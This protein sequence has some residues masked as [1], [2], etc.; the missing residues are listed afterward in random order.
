MDN[1][2]T[3]SHALY[4]PS[5]KMAKDQA[6]GHCT[7]N[8][9]FQTLKFI[10]LEGLQ[11]INRRFESKCNLSQKSLIQNIVRTAKQKMVKYVPTVDY[12]RAIPCLQNR[13]KRKRAIAKH[14]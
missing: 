4:S 14:H 1:R 3:L 13:T 8:L 10:L 6:Q 2:I 5:A 12:K 11:C 7:V 9:Y